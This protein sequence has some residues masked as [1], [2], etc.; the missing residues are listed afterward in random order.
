MFLSAIP[1]GVE[2]NFYDM[3]KVLFLNNVQCLFDDLVS[4]LQHW[5]SNIT[6]LGVR[7]TIKYIYKMKNKFRTHVY[8]IF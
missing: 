5:A 6:N 8:Y 4:Q 2:I 7:R 1:V 3:L